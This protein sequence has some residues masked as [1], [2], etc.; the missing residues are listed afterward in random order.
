S[1]FV[2]R[3]LDHLDLRSFPT[4]RSSDL[5]QNSQFDDEEE[6]G[7]INSGMASSGEG[8]FNFTVPENTPVG[9]YRLRVIMQFP[10]SA[11]N[12]LTPCGTIDSYGV[13]IDYNLQ[14]IE[15]A[16]GITTVEVTTQD[17]IPAEII[18]ENGTLQLVATVTPSDVS[19]EVTWSVEEGT[20][21]VSVD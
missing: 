1:F 21:F 8:A 4:R 16:I 9:I 12:N 14:V 7:Y 13:G 17:N 10:N 18:T 20:E 11:P 2:P 5:N 15:G 6:I 3:D 19:Q